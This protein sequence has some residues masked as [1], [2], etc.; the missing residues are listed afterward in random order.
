MKLMPRSNARSRQARVLSASTPTPYVSHDPREIS[1][2]L[3]LLSP[4]FRYFIK[5]F[6]GQRGAHHSWTLPEASV[7]RMVPFCSIFGANSTVRVRRSRTTG[8]K[9]GEWGRLLPGR[10]RAKNREK[11]TSEDL[12]GCQQAPTFRTLPETDGAPETRRTFIVPAPGSY[13]PQV[14]HPPA[15]LGGLKRSLRAELVAR[16]RGR[17]H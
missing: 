8:V 1:E 17:A 2:T 14:C 5:S 4:S 9:V 16:A 7:A 12:G 13:A 11:L 10:F 3:R 6:S 15:N